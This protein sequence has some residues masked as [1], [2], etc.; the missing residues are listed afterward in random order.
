MK[1]E[2]VIAGLVERNKKLKDQLVASKVSK[3]AVPRVRYEAAKK[4]IEG[5]K[6][7]CKKE[8]GASSEWKR[9]Y[10]AAVKLMYK[11]VQEVKGNSLKRFVEE[12][13]KDQPQLEAVKGILLECKDAKEAGEKIKK[14]SELVETKKRSTSDPLPPITESRGKDKGTKVKEDSK[15]VPTNLMEATD[16]YIK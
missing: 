12:K 13:I 7:R 15:K 6:D 5:L 16:R 3:D 14:L 11:I 8:I 10:E 1:A 4:V 2:D 9:R